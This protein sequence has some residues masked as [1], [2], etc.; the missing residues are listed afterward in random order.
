MLLSGM[1]FLGKRNPQPQQQRKFIERKPQETDSQSSLRRE[2]DVTYRE[3]PRATGQPARS[4]LMQNLDILARP[5]NSGKPQSHDRFG[6]DVFGSNQQQQKQ[7]YKYRIVVEKGV[8]R[9]ERVPIPQD[10]NAPIPQ[11]PQNQGNSRAASMD[12]FNVPRRAAQMQQ[13]NQRN[14]GLS[15]RVR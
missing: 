15:G 11:Q 2:L 3:S 4:S 14:F 8:A 9:R 5:A 1:D 13:N 7:K 10:P 12:I 6:L